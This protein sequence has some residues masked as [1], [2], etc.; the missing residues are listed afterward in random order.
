MFQPVRPIVELNVY[1]ECNNISQFFLCI[2]VQVPKKYL[3]WDF[4]YVYFFVHQPMS[5]DLLR[6]TSSQGHGRGT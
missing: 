3:E 1:R 5:R 4:V 6:L 2:K